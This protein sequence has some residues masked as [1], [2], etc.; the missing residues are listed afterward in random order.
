MDVAHFFAWAHGTWLGQV[1]RDNA[2]I[3]TIGLIVHFAGLSLL[4]GA[5]LVI[6]LTL[7]GVSRTIP[8]GAALKLL[9]VAIIGFVLNLLTGIMFFCFDPERFGLNP[10]FQVKMLLVVLAGAN[11]LWFT[12]AEHREIVQLPAGVRLPLKVRVSASLSLLLWFSV[13]VAGRLIVAF[14]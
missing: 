13:I 5:M 4:M 8:P 3:Y 1:A 7:L 11:A 6:D 14:Q 10:A 2:Y 9:P 12:F